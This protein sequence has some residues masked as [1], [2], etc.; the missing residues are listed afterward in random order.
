MW[1]AKQTLWGE[2][3][4][5]AIF[6]FVTLKLLMKINQSQRSRCTFINLAMMNILV[7]RHSGPSSNRYDDTGHF[8][9]R[10]FEMTPCQ[11]SLRILKVWDELPVSSPASTSHRLPTI[12]DCN[13][14]QPD[15]T[16]PKPT[17]GLPALSRQ[18]VQ[19]LF[20]KDVTAYFAWT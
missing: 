17:H 6:T 7:Y 4:D 15:N 14:R 19:D 2:S 20:L 3:E 1:L 12:R 16:Q 11:I 8:H 9:F 10:D 13:R 18:K 5:L